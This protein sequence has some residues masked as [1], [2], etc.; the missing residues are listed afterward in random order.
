MP[1]ANYLKDKKN[2]IESKYELIHEKKTS[3]FHR[4]TTQREIMI[5]NINT[6]SK[7]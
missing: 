2:K 3:I 1:I 6:K 4:K 5:N 7:L